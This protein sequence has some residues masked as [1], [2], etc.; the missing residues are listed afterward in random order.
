M[1]HTVEVGRSHKG[2]MDT[3]V[4]MVGGTVEAQVDTERYRCP[5]RV[6][7]TTV[8]ANLHV[9]PKVSPDHEYAIRHSTRRPPYLPAWFSVYRRSSATVVWS[10]GR[11]FWRCAPRGDLRSDTRIGK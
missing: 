7:L 6:L 3:Q 11:S 5:R 2:D 10:R 1:A 9:S 8:E 4:A